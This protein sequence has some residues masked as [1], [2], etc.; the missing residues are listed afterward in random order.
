MKRAC[1]FIT[2]ALAVQCFGQASPEL[3]PAKD[4]R[5]LSLIATQGD[6][7]RRYFCEY[8]HLQSRIERHVAF[9]YRLSK[10]AEIPVTEHETV[11]SMMEKA[12]LADLWKTSW[13]PQVRLVTKDA[14]YQSPASFNKAVRDALLKH[15]IR[16]GDILVVSMVE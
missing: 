13:Q 16:S 5:V 2:I 9:V 12:G 14:I 6:D 11:A 3:A 4:R 1:F 15:E 10:N 7:L 8:A